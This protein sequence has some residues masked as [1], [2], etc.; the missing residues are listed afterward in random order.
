MKGEAGVR[1]AG[2]RNLRDEIVAAYA[3]MRLQ[4]REIPCAGKRAAELDVR[5]GDALVRQRHRRGCSE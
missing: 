4:T 5:H 3:P 2:R 1:Q